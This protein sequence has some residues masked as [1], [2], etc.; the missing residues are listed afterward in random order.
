MPDEVS[1]SFQRA[2]EP[3]ERKNPQRNEAF[4]RMPG[5]NPFKFKLGLPKFS[6]PAQMS[7]WFNTT[8]GFVCGV[9]GGFFM[10]TATAAITAAVG[11]LLVFGIIYG[12]MQVNLMRCMN[13]YVN[14]RGTLTPNNLVK[15]ECRVKVGLGRSDGKDRGYWK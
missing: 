10:V 13:E 8:S 7:K 14:E 3:F 2:N 4:E 11:A 15:D 1:E 5:S 9:F 6:A 12:V